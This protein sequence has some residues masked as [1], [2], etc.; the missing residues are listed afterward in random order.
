MTS[1]NDRF[2]PTFLSPLHYGRNAAESVLGD[3]VFA[4]IFQPENSGFFRETSSPLS[5]S[6]CPVRLMDERLA[7]VVAKLIQK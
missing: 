3:L 5:I 4:V 2:Q 7:T 6:H 1:P